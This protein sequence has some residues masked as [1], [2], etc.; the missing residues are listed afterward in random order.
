MTNECAWNNG[1]CSM[2]DKKKLM[3]WTL[4]RTK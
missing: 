1:K 3:I 4:N 2:S